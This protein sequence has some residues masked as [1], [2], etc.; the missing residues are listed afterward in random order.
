MLEDWKTWCW[1]IQTHYWISLVSVVAACI[2]KYWSH[3]M[4]NAV[5]MPK[6]KPKTK[7][8]HL[9]RN[10]T[11]CKSWSCCLMLSTT[12]V[13]S[14]PQMK[15]AT[16]AF[17]RTFTSLKWITAAALPARSRSALHIPPASEPKTLSHRC[18]ARRVWMVC[19]WL[20]EAY[21][22]SINLHN[23]KI[24]SDTGINPRA[25]Q[26]GTTALVAIRNSNK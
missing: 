8:Y 4:Y 1:K 9:T 26:Q 2:I 16:R 10:E 17:C 25:R 7:Q 11:C 13:L 5:S 18:W 6:E 19:G 22:Y 24:D 23:F 12:P 15:T 20:S 3:C 21:F 14:P